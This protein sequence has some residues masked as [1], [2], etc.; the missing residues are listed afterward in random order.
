M[1]SAGRAAV[2]D[3]DG[4]LVDTNHL[5]VVAWWEA[6]R[7]AGHDVPMHAVHRAVGL[8]STDLVAHV[9]GEDRD[10]DQDADISA[11]HKALY[12]QY[13]DRLPA[14][15]GAGDLLRRLHRDGWTVVLAT[16]AGGA[17]L[18][19]LRRAIDADE[20]ISA[21]A[22]ADDVDEGKPSPEPVEHA[23][24]LAGVPAERAVFVGDTVWDMRAGSRAGVRCLGVLCGGIPRADLE[25]AGADA[26]YAD[27]AHLLSALDDGPLK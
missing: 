24:E 26:I 7:Q 16:S 8:P 13:F 18:G 12:G 6:F 15:P 9:L 14:L 23:L 11:G 20:A 17:E 2:F 22:S 3:V 1:G 10:T 27:P 4:T 21:T 25:E 19:A 5:H